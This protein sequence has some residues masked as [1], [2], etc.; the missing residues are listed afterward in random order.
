[1]IFN[2]FV[3]QPLASTWPNNRLR[4]LID[5]CFSEEVRLNQI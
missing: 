4:L 3:F 1:M 5:R 2:L